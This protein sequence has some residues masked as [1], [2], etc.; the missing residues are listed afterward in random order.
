MHLGYSLQRLSRL[1]C[2][3]LPWHRT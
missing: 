3:A 2:R 1:R